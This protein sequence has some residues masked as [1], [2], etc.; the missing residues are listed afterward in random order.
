MFDW[1]T[2]GYVKNKDLPILEGLFNRGLG[3]V[4][5]GM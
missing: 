2:V 1:E 5:S 3:F 4:N